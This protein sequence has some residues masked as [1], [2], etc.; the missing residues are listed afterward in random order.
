MKHIGIVGVTAP[1]AALCYETI[2]S[3]EPCVSRL[4]CGSGA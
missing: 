2:C 1:G 4:R 3:E